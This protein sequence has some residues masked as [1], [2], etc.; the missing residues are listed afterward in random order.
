GLPL[1]RGAAAATGG[2]G[3]RDRRARRRDRIDARRSAPST[4]AIDDEIPRLRA[5][6]L[7]ADPGAPDAGG[8]RYDLS[9]LPIATARPH[10]G[11]PTIALEDLGAIHVDQAFIGTCTNGRLEDLEIAHRVLKGRRVAAGTRLLIVPASSEVL[12]MALERGWVADLLAAGA[13]F[14][15]P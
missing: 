9:R 8:H 13:H 5:G 11:D 3:R 7:W 1:P 2:A 12:T 15:T 6:A 10:R 4:A 14:G